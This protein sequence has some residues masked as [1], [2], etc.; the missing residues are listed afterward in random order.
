MRH[1]L[2]FGT[3][4]NPAAVSRVWFESCGLGHRTV[5]Y[6]ASVESSSGFK[7]GECPACAARD[8][9]GATAR[10]TVGEDDAG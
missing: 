1:D 9:Y 8:N 6:I 2:L 5:I 3:G 10:L 7:R 4:D